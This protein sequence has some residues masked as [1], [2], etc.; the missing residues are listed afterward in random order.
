MG[1]ALCQ[2]IVTRHGGTIA[3][4]SKP[5]IGS[6]F[7]ITLPKKGPESVTGPRD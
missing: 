2:K 7:I 1:L 4:K 3:V 6:T 5:D